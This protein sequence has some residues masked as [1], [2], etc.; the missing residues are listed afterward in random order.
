MDEPRK[1]CAADPEAQ[2]LTA[3]AWES[4]DFRRAAEVL[5]TPSAGARGCA[6][7]PERGHLQALQMAVGWTIG[8][9]DTIESVKAMDMDISKIF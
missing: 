2:A 1:L 7:N 5:A 3:A 6:V 9:F 8:G 4:E